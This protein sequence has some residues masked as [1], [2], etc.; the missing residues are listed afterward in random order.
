VGGGVQ[1][2]GG[3]LVLADQEAGGA[4]GVVSISTVGRRVAMMRR[5]VTLAKLDERRHR[6]L[7]FG[8]TRETRLRE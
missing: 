3:E 2:R 8:V 1:A 4:H 7:R 5:A 6:A